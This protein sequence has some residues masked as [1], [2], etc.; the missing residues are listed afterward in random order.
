MNCDEKN[1][2]KNIINKNLY[3]RFWKVSWWLTY[4]FNMFLYTGCWGEAEV[5]DSQSEGQ[6]LGQASG[7]G[8]T[9]A[10]APYRKH[11]LQVDYLEKWFIL[12]RLETQNFILLNNW[13][14]NK[15]ETS[16][17]F[18]KDIGVK[19]KIFM[20]KLHMF[21]YIQEL[22]DQCRKLSLEKIYYANLVLDRVAAF[23][24]KLLF[25]W[26]DFFMNLSIV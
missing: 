13:S 5:G 19:M 11:S 15:H 6:V 23:G 18:T 7:C 3:F 21:L 25:K 24:L 22:L 26:R 9:R 10:G 2:I 12:N 17:E 16:W 8:G 20:H 14:F 4:K 1:T